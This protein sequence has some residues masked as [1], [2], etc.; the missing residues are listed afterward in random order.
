MTP[1]MKR[2][3]LKCCLAAASVCVFFTATPAT[4]GQTNF[5]PVI[6]FH[7]ADHVYD[8]WAGLIWGSDGRLYGTSVAGGISNFGTVF[9][10]NPDGTGLTILK[11]FTDTNSSAA[12]QTALALGTN[13]TL[14]GTTYGGG[15]FHAGT[16]FK[17]DQ[18]GSNFTVLHNIQGGTDGSNTYSPL[19]VGSDGALYGTTFFANSATRGTVF[20]MDENG[21]NY[22]ILH[23]FTGVPNDGQQPRGRLI[24]STNGLVYG[25]TTFGG[26]FNRGTVF[27]MDK[28]GGNY[29][30][31]SFTSA[32]S[33]GSPEAGVLEASD[34]LLYGT[35]YHGG[36]GSQGSVFAVSTDLFSY[37]AALYKFTNTN[38][39]GKWPNTELVEGADGALYGL[40]QQGGNP[41]HPGGTIFK[42]N[43]DG[44]GYVV[45]RDF[46]S[47]IGGDYP[48]GGLLK[49]TNGV[50][51]GTTAHG[52]PGDGCVFAL[53]SSPLPSR[54]LSLS[55]T[56]GSNVVQFTATSSI[57]YD[58]QRSL[59]LNSWF[60][61]GTFT[62]PFNGQITYTDLSP[63]QPNA[64][65][66]LKQ[67]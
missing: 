46:D 67:D 18:N 43:K 26:A 54:A 61:M 50:F 41:S 66:R 2:L 22:A 33:L 62:A 21:S 17:L 65:Y 56:N 1:V 64:F 59:D 24:E 23:T 31:F 34:G 16:V 11:S 12:P 10:V 48:Q 38:G 44:N 36:T 19:L 27:S 57:Q 52:G 5:T 51:Y 4:R 39:D 3:L 63:P 49:G 55:T 60:S 9:R 6:I 7:L 30:F 53:N 58:V 40:T 37:Y 14:F 45:L 28:N 13:G 29:W 25:T 35:L 15:T 42:L 32:D 8:P 47:T 20:K